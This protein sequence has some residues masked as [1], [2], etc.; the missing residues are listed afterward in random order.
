MTYGRSKTI[1]L[2]QYNNTMDMSFNFSTASEFA[3][4]KPYCSINSYKQYGLKLIK[5]E[6]FYTWKSSFLEE[7]LSLKTQGVSSASQA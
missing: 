3:L 7:Q 6:E 1:E 5:I 2:A 4:K